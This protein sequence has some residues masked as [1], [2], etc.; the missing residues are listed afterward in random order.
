MYNQ[1]NNSILAASAFVKYL[2]S[3]K[4]I[5]IHVSHPLSKSGS[6]EYLWTEL[7]FEPNAAQFL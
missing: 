6:E 7:Y 3:Q 5:E 2:N 4:E 1:T